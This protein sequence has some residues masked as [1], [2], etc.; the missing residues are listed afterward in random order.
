MCG[1]YVDSDSVIYDAIKV[2][3]SFT[4]AQEINVTDSLKIKAILNI[5][6]AA[7]PTEE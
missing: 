2:K 4:G 6:Y 5:I 1:D 3:V 7:P